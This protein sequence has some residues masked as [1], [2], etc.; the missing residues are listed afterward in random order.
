MPPSQNLQECPEIHLPWCPKLYSGSHGGLVESSNWAALR[1]A[2]PY[3]K[4]FSLPLPAHHGLAA[5]AKQR[6]QNKVPIL[7]RKG[8]NSKQAGGGYAPLLA[9][10]ECLSAGGTVWPLEPS[11]VGT[12]WWCYYW[13]LGAACGH[14]VASL[15][16]PQGSVSAPDPGAHFEELN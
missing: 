13:G 7:S 2:H 10:V 5:D 11:L 15:K 1:S 6:L 12:C 16:M 14:R 9:D 3:L 8:E 4:A